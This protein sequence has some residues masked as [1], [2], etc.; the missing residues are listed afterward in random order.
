MKKILLGLFISL[1][2][3]GMVW[4]C[5]STDK[6]AK[7]FK[8]IFIGG[9]VKVL[10]VQPSPVPGICEVIVEARGQ[11]RLTYVDETG[12]Y[13]IVGRLIDIVT[14]KDLTQERLA[15][16]MRLNPEQMK[17]LDTLV[18][19]SM[20]HGPVVY[21]VT[22]PDCPHCK[23][24]EKSILPLAEKGKIT[25]KV[26]LMPLERLHPHA[27]KKAIGIICDKKGLKEMLAGYEGSQ[28]EQGRQKVE[29]TEKTLLSLGIRATPTYIFSDG[30]VISGVLPAEKVLSLAGASK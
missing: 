7:E 5:P 20:G 26:I 25:V 27:K 19:F 23:R 3:G 17:K 12:R 8:S 2:F 28:C 18:A 11:K 14:R 13:L 16:L 24:A 4:A 10:K 15:E 30:R 29:A 21:L 22:D 1:A 6:V 9:A